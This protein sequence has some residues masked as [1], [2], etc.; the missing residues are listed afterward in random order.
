MCSF[1]PH[2]LIVL[3]QKWNGSYF[4]NTSLGDLG[5]IYQLGH[6]GLSCEFP[7]ETIRNMVV[8]ALNGVHKVKYRYC[9]CTATH[10]PTNLQQL[11][12]VRWYPAT[13]TD[14]RTCATFETLD[15]FRDLNVAGNVNVNDFVTVLERKTDATGMDSVPVSFP[16]F[17]S[18]T[19]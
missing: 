14:P 12:R 19:S 1:L 9:S 6:G 11:M 10:R 13:T 17:L 8:I 16:L 18:I 2:R 5:L 15:L 3:P 4:E 7:D